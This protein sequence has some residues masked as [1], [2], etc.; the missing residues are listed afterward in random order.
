MIFNV[1]IFFLMML[2]AVLCFVCSDKF[3][4]GQWLHLI[5]G[6]ND[7]S[8]TQK[9]R[10]NLKK[11]SQNAS[12]VA[13]VAGIYLVYLSVALQFILQDI[14]TLLFNL[15]LLGIPSLL[16]LIYVIFKTKDSQKYYH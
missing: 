15:L 9:E 12:K 11:I 2:L 16:F 1:V 3:S 8:L 6:Y 10:V 4:K 14:F 13:L 5:A 7:L